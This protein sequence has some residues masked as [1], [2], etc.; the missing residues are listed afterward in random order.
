MEDKIYELII[1]GSGVAGI[2]AGTYAGRALIDT[3]IIE[4][5]PVSG[6]QIVKTHE[7]DNYP[8][9]PNVSGFE[10]GQKLSKHVNQYELDHVNGEVEK[11]EVNDG[12]KEIRL[13][14]GK[15][16]KG[17]TVII[18]TGS[19]PRKLNIPGED[20]LQGMGVSY[21]ATCDGAFFRNKATAIVGGGDTAV[22]DALFLARLCEKV[23]LIHR[24][25]EFRA[26]KV[27]LEKA[28][29]SDNIEILTNS[30][31][32]EINGSE[33]VE[34]IR[35]FNNKT[36]ETKELEVDAIFVAVGNL[37][38]ADAFK[39]IVDMDESGY[40]IAEED[41]KTNIPGVYAAGDIR[42]KS[43]RQV[44]TAASDGANVIHSVEKY[45][46]GVSW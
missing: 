17:K 18:S 1:V 10:L 35:V 44:I 23:Y 20:K 3:L 32:K 24:R 11:F 39:G 31:V 4:R 8:G 14:N 26:T 27:Y 21:C 43:L 22:E 37:P 6:G 9:L 19:D 7:I 36:N 34:E 30:E 40:I 28:N 12:I 13:D 25:D 38:N 29:N 45:L 42:T 2:T 5:L 33:F 15:V 46:N 16:Y 41:G